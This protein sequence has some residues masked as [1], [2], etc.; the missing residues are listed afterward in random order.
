MVITDRIDQSY[1]PLCG[2]DADVRGIGF[3]GI[4]SVSG[5]N[6]HDVKCNCCGNFLI[7]D[8]VFKEVETL[9]AYAALSGTARELTELKQPPVE[10][11]KDNLKSLINLAPKTIRDKRQRLLHTFVRMYP[12][13][14]QRVTLDLKTDF[15]LAYAKSEAELAFILLY[16]QDETLA[17][18]SLALG[19]SSA[20]VTLTARGWEEADAIDK[21]VAQREKAFV[22]MWFNDEMKSVYEKSIG[23]AIEK[24]GYLPIRIDLQEHSD[25]IIDRI[26]A[27]IKESRFV[28]ADFTGHRA[29]VYFEAGFAKGLGL[30]V[31]WMCKKTYMK[32]LHFDI[33][34]FNVIDW[35]DGK[36][37]EER[38]FNR[39][40]Y[41]LGYGPLHDPRTLV[42]ADSSSS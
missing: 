5:I 21:L 8:D 35:R 34:G 40:R 24:T 30:N 10:I 9:G 25:S 41:I 23:P 28:V 29:G 7:M 38:L 19:D 14:G 26:L 20:L 4:P 33:K 11:T 37:L 15:P 13:F 27:E 17:T 12:V 36:D 3:V 6:A 31:I 2:Q 32:K 39:I 18:C 1:C 22:A 16:L 42:K